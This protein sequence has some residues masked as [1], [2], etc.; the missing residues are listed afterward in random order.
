[1]VITQ[2]ADGQ[3]AGPV[4]VP[5]PLR[6]TQVFGPDTSQHRLYAQAIHPIVEEVLE[7]FNCT[8]FAY[9][10]TGTGKTFT[11]EGG[12]R[13]RGSQPESPNLETNSAGVIP[14]AINH[15]FQYL[16]QTNT[17]YTVKC[18]FLELYNEETTDLLAVGGNNGNGNN[19]SGVQNK[20]RIM[21]DRGGV[22]IH[23]LEENVVRNEK[24]IYTL[25]DRGSAQRKTAET[26]L[27]KQ[28]SRSHSVFIITVHMRELND[29]EEVIKTGKLYLVDLAGSENISRSG[30]VDVRAKEVFF[31]FL[32][33]RSSA[34]SWGRRLQHCCYV[35]HTPH[36]CYLSFCISTPHVC[37][38]THPPQ[39]I[40]PSAHI[41]PP[42]FAVLHTLSLPTRRV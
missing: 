8:I 2:H 16:E 30:A 1:M 27:N 17:D 4:I 10:Q 14:R 28:S 9:G 32:G 29:G 21:E 7:G 41:H 36:E 22:I 11:M 37:I 34:L 25:L 35:V 24:D 13:D 42:V 39:H 33:E 40:S 5:H 12:E 38:T 6:H 23:G 26:L 18:S 31:L 19:D 3:M 15:I 20:L